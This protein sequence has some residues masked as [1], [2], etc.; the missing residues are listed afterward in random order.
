MK[1]LM[2]AAVMSAFAIASAS[3]Q[4]CS[5]IVNG[6]ELKGAARTSHMKSCCEKTAIDKNGKA[7]H[8]IVKKQHVDKCIKGA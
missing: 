5:P 7:M 6:K 4:E 2:L 8:G 1:K 3:A